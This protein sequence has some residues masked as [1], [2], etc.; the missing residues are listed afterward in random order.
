MKIKESAENYLEAILMLKNKNGSVRSID[1][2]NYLNFTKPSVSVAMKSFREEGY[3]TV[4][5]DG[6]ILL[7][8]KGLAIAE[9]MFERHQIIAKALMALGVD[10]ETAY[11]DSCK[12][13]HDISSL[14]FEKIKEH[15]TKHNIF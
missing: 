15:L 13:E 2:A 8:E 7:T 14:S 5:A 1:I 4:D 3:I 6:G 9:K 12:I 10:E 11:E